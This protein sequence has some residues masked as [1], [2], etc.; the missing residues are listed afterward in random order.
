MPEV[1]RVSECL[2]CGAPLAGPYC[3]HCGQR[4]RYDRL[5]LVQIFNDIRED[6][7]CGDLSFMRTIK[8]MLLAPGR[9][10]QEY[11]QGKRKSLV[12]PLKF[13]FWTL[14]LL[15]GF[16]YFLGLE[17]DLG[18]SDTVLEG[19]ELESSEAEALQRSSDMMRGFILQHVDVLIFFFHPVFALSLYLLFRRKGFNFTEVFSA[20]LLV[21]GQLNIYKIIILPLALLSKALVVGVEL[22][23]TFLYT[24]WFLIS[25]F[26]LRVWHGILLSPVVAV[27]YF[28][29]MAVIIIPATIVYLLWLN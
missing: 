15:I 8:G 12:N 6:L 18:I 22:G 4:G 13:C 27:L 24:T 21:N 19:V 17:M 14:A 3:T 28:A 26:G 16:T 10:C 20:V 1:Q 11:I 29:S 7:V 23:I 2:N 5:R 25:F 9:T